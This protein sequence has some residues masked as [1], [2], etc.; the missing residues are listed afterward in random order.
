VQATV[1]SETLRVT[2]QKRFDDID[3]LD[4][5]IDV[6]QEWLETVG[7]NLA[8]RLLDDYPVDG[9]ESD[10]IIA[11]AEI[12]LQTAKDFD[13]EDTVCFYPSEY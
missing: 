4:D 2:Y 7:Y 12:M 8:S 6:A 11:R 9:K 13:R 10:R 1:T 5:D 3:T